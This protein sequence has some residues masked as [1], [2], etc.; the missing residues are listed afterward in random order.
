MGVP[1]PVA[2]LSGDDLAPEVNLA[3]DRPF[4]SQVSRSF[5]ASTA[6]ERRLMLPWKL[7]IFEL[8][9]QLRCGLG[10]FSHL[11]PKPGKTC[12]IPSS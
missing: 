1:S 9:L 6:L 4:G 12:H 2:E 5:A 8:G 3:D 10:P 11:R 7:D